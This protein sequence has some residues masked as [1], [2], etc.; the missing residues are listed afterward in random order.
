[1]VHEIEAGTLKSQPSNLKPLIA[2]M[3]AYRS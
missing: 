3:K 2:T 1:M